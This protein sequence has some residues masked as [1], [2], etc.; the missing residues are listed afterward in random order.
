MRYASPPS[1]RF[2]TFIA[3]ASYAAAVIALVVFGLWLFIAKPLTQYEVTLGDGT[4]ATCIVVGIRGGGA[5]NCIPHVVAGEDDV[6]GE[7][8]TP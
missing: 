6:V 8:V 2:D 5:M 7:E 1:E 3:I 4:K